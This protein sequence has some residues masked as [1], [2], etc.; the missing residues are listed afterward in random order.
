MKK[1]LW[2]GDA[3]CESG[4]AKVTHQILEFLRYNLDVHVLG[5]NHR[6]DPH[7][8]PYPIYPAWVMGCQDFIGLCRIQDTIEIVKPDIIVILTDPWHVKQYHDRIRKY[9]EAPIVGMIPVD[10]KNTPGR[11]LNLLNHTIFWTHFAEQEALSSGFTGDSSIIPL[12]VDL[13]VYKNYDNPRTDVGL[14][15]ELLDVFIVG[16]ANRNQPRKRQDLTIQYF[17]EWVKEYK[18]DDAYLFLHIGPTGEH[19][20]DAHQLMEYYGLHK[21]LI[22]SEP[23]PWKGITEVELAKIYNCFDIQV[24]TTQG[25]GWGLTTLEGMACGVPQ[26]VPDWSALGEWATAAIKV[27]CTN[28]ICTPGRWN[29]VGG[30]PDKDE[31]IQVLNAL[32]ETEQSRMNLIDQGFELVAQREYRWSNIG[33]RVADVVQR[34]MKSREIPAAV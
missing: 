24:S 13:N 5:I 7:S 6:G 28:Q 29:T 14:P 26:I 20:Y 25:E 32:Y 34:V 18:V 30:V 19:G 3:A 9:S 10:G 11:W 22:R 8:Y 31:F 27:P 12:G 33:L 2:I 4:F 21:R 15:P 23:E 17:A 1:L 16:N